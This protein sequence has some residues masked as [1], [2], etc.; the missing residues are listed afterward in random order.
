[1]FA[2]FSDLKFMPHKSDGIAQ[3]RFQQRRCNGAMLL[4]LTESDLVNDFGIR[5]RTHRERILNAIEAVKMSDDDDDDD[6]DNVDDDD[7]YADDDIEEDEEDD[8]SDDD[9]PSTPAIGGLSSLH[10]AYL[11]DPLLT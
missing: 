2:I 11:P 8:V 6:D 1:L 10:H 7:D 5:N 3:P 4:E 9:T